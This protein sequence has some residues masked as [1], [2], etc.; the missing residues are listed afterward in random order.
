[1]L[2]HQIALHK[3]QIDKIDF[4]WLDK[5]TLLI[6]ENMKSLIEE[7]VEENRELE[8]ALNEEPWNSNWIGNL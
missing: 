6:I 4:S 2:K 5:R 3:A 8:Q 7:L 1:M